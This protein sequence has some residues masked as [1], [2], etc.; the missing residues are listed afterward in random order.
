MP[1]EHR[2]KVIFDTN[3]WISYLIGSQLGGLTELL[4]TKKIE[5]VLS[6]QLRTELTEITKRKKFQKYFDQQKVN[7]LFGN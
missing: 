6:E 7:E 4:R 3:I 1:S 5:L 2:I